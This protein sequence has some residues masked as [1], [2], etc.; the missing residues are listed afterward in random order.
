MITTGQLDF[1]VFVIYSLAE[2]WNM[3]P[4]EVYGILADSGI[5]DSYIIECYDMLH[6][7]GRE[8]LVDDITEFAREKGIHI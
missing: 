6:T 4:R 3:F 5:L 7:L 8:Y 2:S 1:S